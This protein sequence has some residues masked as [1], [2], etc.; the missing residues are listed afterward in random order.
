M[1]LITGCTGAEGAWFRNDKWADELY[2][3]AVSRSKESRFSA[4]VESVAAPGRDVREND[5]VGIDCSNVGDGY[6]TVWLKSANLKKM[7]MQVSFGDDV[8]SY[9][10]SPDGA[11]VF[12]LACGTG[13]YK[14]SI[15]ENVEGTKYA[16]VLSDTVDAKITDEFAPFL[17]PNQYVNYTNAPVTRALAEVISEQETDLLALV[18]LV[19]RF[20]IARMS[21]DKQLAASV[22]DGYLP[23][24]DRDLEKGT[25]ICFDYAAIMAAVLRCMNIPCRLVTGY[26]GTAYHAWISVWSEDEGWLDKVIYFDGK[27]WQRADPTFADSDASS[28]KIQ[29]YIGDGSNYLE[30]HYY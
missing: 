22:Q 24:L 10:L 9:T 26:A 21:Y 8:C 2:E 19:F 6:I 18:D 14:I 20:V 28:G 3:E 23:D 15:F 16:L 12:P 11:E 17:R 27:G 25:G 1:T 30:K 13:E 29:D 7:K 4:P 5:K